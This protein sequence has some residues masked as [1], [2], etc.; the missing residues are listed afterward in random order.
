[1]PPSSLCR[2]ARSLPTPNARPLPFPAA[3]T[4]G[5]SPQRG[6]RQPAA[7]CSQSLLGPGVKASAGTLGAQPTR[8]DGESCGAAEGRVTTR[9]CAL[10]TTA[11]SD[12]ASLTRHASARARSSCDAPR[13]P[14]CYG[15]WQAAHTAPDDAQMR[16][17]LP[18]KRRRVI[19][20]RARAR[21]TRRPRDWTTINGGATCPNSTNASAR[22]KP[23]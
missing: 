10:R 16:G 13:I 5:S 21:S 2:P 23:N 19:K 6:G 11:G 12:Y 22:S 15:K 4:D 3:T 14:I 20:P 1:M 9:K 18:P 17:G 7:R 8:R